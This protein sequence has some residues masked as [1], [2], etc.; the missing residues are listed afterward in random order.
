MIVKQ[1]IEWYE[2]YSELKK[3]D[4]FSHAEFAHWRHMP[5]T[6]RIYSGEGVYNCTK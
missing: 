1:D 2:D 3:T 6:Y 5:I 4:S